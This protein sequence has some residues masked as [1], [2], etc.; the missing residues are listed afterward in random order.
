VRGLQTTSMAMT[1]A[2]RDLSAALRN[3][4]DSRGVVAQIE[5]ANNRL[6]HSLES[7]AKAVDKLLR[8]LKSDLLHV[9]IPLIAGAT[10]LVGMLGGMAIQG[11]RNSIPTAA[12]PTPTVA[13]PVP[14][15]EPQQNP[16]VSGDPKQQ[17]HRQGK[18]KHSP[19][20]ER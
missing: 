7:R 10:L 2:Q 8:D 20:R 3:L 4:S 5:T 17:Q 15:P 9:W 1:S 19:E 16:A 6:T 13:E 14:L 11:W 18:A 12:T